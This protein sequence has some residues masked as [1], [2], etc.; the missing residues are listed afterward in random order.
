MIGNGPESCNPAHV[1]LTLEVSRPCT[2]PSTEDTV[3]LN[4]ELEVRGDN[5]EREMCQY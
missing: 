5:V 2:V 1:H 3:K 4:D